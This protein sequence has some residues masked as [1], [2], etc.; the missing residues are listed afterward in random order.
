[1]KLSKQH[2]KYCTACSTCVNLCPKHCIS[3]KENHEGFLYPFIESVDCIECGI[4]TKNC[5]VLH[6]Y[7]KRKP[8]KIISAI[9]P[10]DEI[11]KQSSSGGIFSYLAEKVI[12]NNG[13]VFGARY[14]DKW[15]VEL[16][17]TETKEGLDVFRGSKY[18]QAKNNNTFIRCK[19]F[20]DK[21]KTV[22]YSGTPCQI[23]GLNHYLKKSYDNLLTVE[24]A[25]LGVPSPKVWKMYLSEISD[26]MPITNISMRNKDIEGWHN[27]HFY[28]ELKNNDKTISK[29][30]K[31]YENEYM[32]AFIN[33][34]IFRPSCHN[35]KARNNRS[36]ADITIADFWGVEIVHP[37]MDDDK[38]TSLVLI[39]TSKG[40]KMIE[41]SIFHHKT[42][43]QR[44][45][46][47]Y[48]KS[49][50]SDPI[51][52]CTRAV[53]FSKLDNTDS[54]IRLIHESMK[55]SFCQRVYMKFRKFFNI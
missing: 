53:F 29:S 39:N 50:I 42:I 3:L 52:L 4:C 40:A 19:S 14:N 23:A 5:P 49:L 25:C 41:S 17:F 13:I 16:D 55:L 2:L 33:G 20:L 8:L 9:N 7:E 27:Y 32:V 11:R 47:R 24:V 51:P 30:W 38:G 43:S 6:P 1:M 45:G 31:Y 28:I 34:M 54:V 26:N 18:V 44:E 48:N 35:C 22:L 37:E 36:H 46:V 15:Q 10:Y 12:E 21:G